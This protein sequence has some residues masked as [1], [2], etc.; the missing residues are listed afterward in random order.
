MSEYINKESLY[1]R[2]EEIEQEK[3]ALKVDMM[4]EFKVS[5]EMIKRQFKA[6]EDK[7]KDEAKKIKKIL[8]IAE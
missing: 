6:D 8:K 1:Q 3:K 4:T 7:L 2:L 5:K